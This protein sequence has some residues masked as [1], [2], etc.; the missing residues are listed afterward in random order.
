MSEPTVAPGKGWRVGA[1]MLPFPVPPGTPLGGYAAREGPATGTRDELTVGALF[2]EQGGWRLAV[3]A[4]DVVA[5]DVAL[6]GE[7]AAIAGL[8]PGEVLIAASHTHSGPAGVI[9]RLHPADPGRLDP[10]LRARL[11]ATAAAAIR[12]ARASAEPAT[13]AFGQATVAG[14]AANRID[15]GWSRDDR[16]SVL[17]AWRGDGSPLAALV[18]FACHPTILPATSRVV[19]ADYPGAMRAHLAA[20]LA[21]GGAAPLVFFANGSAGDV[22]TRYTRRGQ[23][24]AEVERVGMEVAMA[25][26]DAIRASHSLGSG[27]G[28]AEERVRLARRTLSSPNQPE[29]PDPAESAAASDRG[30]ATRAQGAAMLAALAAAP[31]EAV[32]EAVVVGGWRLGELVL[33]AVPGELSASLGQAIVAA[34]PGPTLVVGYANGYVGYLPDR[35]AHAAGSYEAL[36]SPYE[37]G[38][39]EAVAEAA[40][41]LAAQLDR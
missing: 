2:L 16:V 11:A 24:A 28:R 21:T 14:I 23:D 33:V 39:G 5:V 34:R 38:A 32:P 1:R 19:S 31:A 29:P 13:L 6:A 26:G 15:P 9:D 8:A 41:E 27:V 35:A 18:H 22:S 25:A 3:V 10:P 17:S 12:D 7:V 20:S 37:D 40:A 36:A 30:A 4:A